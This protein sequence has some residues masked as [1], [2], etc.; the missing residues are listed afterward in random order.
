MPAKPISPFGLQICQHKWI[1]LDNFAVNHLTYQIESDFY[2]TLLGEFVRICKFRDCF[3]HLQVLVL[4]RVLL[5]N[6][7][8]FGVIRWYHFTETFKKMLDIFPAK[9]PALNRF[10]NDEGKNRKWFPWP[11]S[12]WNIKFYYLILEL[13]TAATYNFIASIFCSLGVCLINTCRTW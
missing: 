11:F 4:F 3:K 5:N 10:G 8:L 9:Q 13:I 1:V 12:I 7:G 2:E 6:P